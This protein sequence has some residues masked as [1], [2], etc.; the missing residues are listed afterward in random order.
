MH[1]L[2]GKN[3]LVTGATGLVGGHLTEKL[4]AMGAY[5]H[6]TQRSFTPWSYFSDRKLGEKVLSAICDIKD[7]QRVLDVVTR[8]EIE[9]IFH[10]AAQP[11]VNTAFVNPQETLET[12]IMGTVNVLEAAR[13][14]PLIKGVVVASSDKAYG[15]KCDNATE[16]APMAGDH[17]YDV[18]KSCTD[19]IARTYART[20]SLPVA[21]TRFGNIYG[22]GDLNLNRIVPGIMKAI[23]CG[24]TLALRSNGLFVRDYVFVKDVADG[25]VTLMEQ[26]EIARGEAFNFSTGYNF[27]VLE[28]I[29]QISGTLGRKCNYTILNNQENEIP[30]QSLNFDKAIQRLG[31]QST[32]S[33]ETGIRETSE[34]Y[35]RHFDQ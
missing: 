4:I 13:R 18:S 20:Y 16:D 1:A 27:P 8:Y 34:W 19:L 25:Y 6:I 3:V 26:M 30:T 23:W 29:K 10:A 7:A 17:P 24:E 12:N 32:R 14:S 33:F 15:K 11:I 2:K 31:W 28:L 21:V 9:Y 35:R 5:V 22:P